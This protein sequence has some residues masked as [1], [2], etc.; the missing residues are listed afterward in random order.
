MQQFKN[1]SLGQKFS[2]ITDHL[3]FF[4]IYSFK[5]PDGM[6]ARWIEK[7]GQ[8]NF[9]I[10][11]RAGKK[12]LLADIMSRMITEDDEPTAFVNASAIT[13]DQSNTIYGS[14]GWQLDKLQKIELQD[15][16]QNDNVLKEVY[17]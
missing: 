9:D 8:I 12:I 17:S 1:Y 16:Q 3:A 4:W 5:E 15:S 7:S 14:R 2:F 11:H 13:A 6:V 10:R